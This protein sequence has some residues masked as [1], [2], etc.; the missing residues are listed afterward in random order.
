VIAA[1]ASQAA[2]E[3]DGVTLTS[4]AGSGVSD[5]VGKKSLKKGIKVALD[6]NRVTVDVY[7]LTAYGKQI[8]SVA[9]KVQDRVSSSLQSM[10]G[11]TVSMVNVHVSGII[12]DKEAKSR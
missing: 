3:I 4:A 9:Q 12:F 2:G 8:P 6:E 11:L 5:L 7:L 10:T 1:I